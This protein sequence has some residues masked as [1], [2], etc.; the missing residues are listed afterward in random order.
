MPGIAVTDL[1]GRVLA[2][3]Y[4]LLAPVGTGAS[5]RVYLAD[6]VR[7]RRRVAV[8]VLHGAL[9]DDAAF[10]RRFR[11]EA[12]VAAALHH[13]HIVTVHDWGEDT[14]PFM[15]LEMLSGGSLRGMLDRGT[16]L[17]PAQTA[18]IARDVASALEYAHARGIVHRDIK[19]ANLLFDEHG[20]VRVAD[21]GLARALAE[22][23]WTEPAGGMLGTVRYASPEQALGAPLDA[24]SDLYS[25]AVVCVESVTG[26][27]PFATDTA[28]GTLTAR[29]QRPLLAPDELG[30]LRA[31]V[32]RAGRVEPSERYPDAATM[33]A[34]LAAVVDALPR[35]APLVLAGA[36]DSHDP[37]P[38]RT[39]VEPTAELFDQD[40][41][42][43][44]VEA[45]VRRNR[46][47][48]GRRLVPFVVA[49]AVVLALSGAAFGLTR[50]GT[51]A[52]PAEVPGLVGRSEADAAAAARAA[53]VGFAVSE[54][55]A[56]DDPAGVVLDQDPPA[57]SWLSGD[58]AVRIVVSSGPAP[59]EVPDLRNLTLADATERLDRLGLV[60]EATEAF[61]E[62]VAAGRVVSQSV[63]PNEQVAPDTAVA[64]VVSQGPAP[65]AIP[66]LRDVPYDEA[67]GTL[68]D[69]GLAP[70]RQDAFDN[71]VA[72]GRVI[73][74]EP[75]AGTEVQKGAEVIVVVSRGPDL[76]EVPRV[77]G[78]T[79][80]DATEVL[81]DAGFEVEI[82]GRFRPGRE[83]TAQSPAPGSQVPRGS[84]VTIRL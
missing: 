67:A 82:A 37:H 80:E 72:E 77:R 62:T 13:P 47:A 6:D 33:R 56:S 69:A 39:H 64:V 7:L 32:E 50:L 3:R 78:L 45:I 15:V 79:V 74:T 61:D 71:D 9:A 51:G 2:G 1:A 41:A 28:L 8:K 27:V 52:M 19:P 83:V 75:A 58:D 22:A 24:R 16:L 76:V 29:T 57:G 59:V 20:I 25:L 30:P 46:P 65:I 17:S 54:R 60:I 4:R 70:T 11:A 81:T 48:N 23:S 21:F 26:R 34:A 42:P 14:V 38:T 36:E 53:G 5:G 18:W 10:L 63:A 68:T 43:E 84:V 44:P 55:R 40:A 12:Q 49:L 31:V 66:D 73:R 35:P